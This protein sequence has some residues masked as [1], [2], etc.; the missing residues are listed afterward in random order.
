MLSVF[1]LISGIEVSTLGALF[2]LSCLQTVRYH[3]YSVHVLLGMGY[4]TEDDIF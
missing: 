1:P 3:R 2:L 4:L